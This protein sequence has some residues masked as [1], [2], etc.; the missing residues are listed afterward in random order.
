V[1]AEDRIVG[2]LLGTAVGDALGLAA[3]GMSA[4]QIARRWGRLDRYRFLGRRGFVSDDT[5]QSALVGWFWR[6][7]PTRPLWPSPATWRS[8]RSSWLTGSAGWCPEAADRRRPA[9]LLRCPAGSPIMTER[10][11]LSDSY[12]LE[13]EARVL[14]CKEHEG[15]PAA[16]LDRTA[17]Y[18]ESGGQPW[19]TG[20][21]GEAS[22]L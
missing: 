12:T 14:A 6:L 13:F 20:T 21:L 17:F 18:A 10:L 2:A 1:S 15:R 16:I 8:T 5:E 9:A 4:R 7:P 11:H 3:E 19:D 22:V